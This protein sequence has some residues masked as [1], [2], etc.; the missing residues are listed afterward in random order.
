MQDERTRLPMKSLGRDDKKTEEVCVGS[1]AFGP[2]NSSA[3][4][5]RLRGEIIASSPS[6][7]AFAQNFLKRPQ[8]CTSVAFADPPPPTTFHQ[9][10]S[11][12]FLLGR[13]RIT[14]VEASSFRT[15]RWKERT[16]PPKYAFDVQRGPDHG[17]KGVH[18]EKGPRRRRYKVGASREIFT[19]R[20][21]FEVRKSSLH[22]WPLSDPDA[23]T[24]LH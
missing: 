9:F 12:R 24:E 14:L 21:I 10:V 15:G 23:G 4:E 1:V 18:P 8:F 19:R 17:Q 20:Q 2:K 16:A 3:S 22:V 11:L 5:F 13:R 7:G 6:K